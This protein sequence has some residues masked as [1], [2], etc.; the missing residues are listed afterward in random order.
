VEAKRVPEFLATAKKRGVKV[1]RYDSDKSYIGSHHRDFRVINSDTP[2]FTTEIENLMVQ[3]GFE[4]LAIEITKE[5]HPI[6]T[7][8]NTN[9]VHKGFTSN[10]CTQTSTDDFASPVFHS[11][12]SAKWKHRNKV[13]T[14]IAEHLH[15]GIRGSTPVIYGDMDRNKSFTS[16]PEAFGD[17][18][19]RI[20][21]LTGA[22]QTELHP[23][24]IHTDTHNDGSPRGRAFNYDYVVIAWWCFT[25][26]GIVYRVT[27]LGYSRRSIVDY[28]DRRV[29]LTQ[30]T[31]DYFRPW[32][33]SLPDHRKEIDHRL[34]SQSYGEAAIDGDGNLARKPHMNKCVHYAGYGDILLEVSNANPRFVML[35]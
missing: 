7:A 14:E 15:D 17:I 22:L 28:L 25:V 32:F 23:L 24:F 18:E 3:L 8:R 27:I 29:E 33:A 20:E 16:A 30:F 1:H 4:E 35:C 2:E 11:N 21:T 34:F 12:C 26:D 5:E 13:M 19:C 10:V 31:D 9:Q 6:N